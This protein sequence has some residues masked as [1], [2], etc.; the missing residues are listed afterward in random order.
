MKHKSGLLDV[1]KVG[2]ARIIASIEL[3][4][5]LLVKKTKYV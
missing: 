1:E 5:I 4:I 2:R 3:I